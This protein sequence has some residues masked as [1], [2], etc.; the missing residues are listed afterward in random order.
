MEQKI[1]G[2]YPDSIRAFHLPEYDEIPDTGLYLDQAARYV[3]ETLHP[4]PGAGVTGS[5]VS[6][7]VKRNL[8][9]NPIRKQYGREQLAHLIFI[10]MAKSVLSI[11][12]LRLLVQL[13]RSTCDSRAA[14]GYFRTE[15]ERALRCAV[16]SETEL[17][18]PGAQDSREKRIL[19][20]AIAAIAHKL[21]LNA[22]LDQLR[23]GE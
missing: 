19:H 14:Y 12:D 8:L 4:L 16:G 13:Q 10:A 9:A 6:N 22:Q 5:M 2:A 11:E 1:D 7:Y 3:S 21:C 20:T 17:S 18:L 23:G 15:L